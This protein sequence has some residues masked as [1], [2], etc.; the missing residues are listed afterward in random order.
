MVARGPWLLFTDADTKHAPNSVASGLQEARESSA[1]LLSYSPKQEVGSLAERAL[2]PVIFA[3]LA[4][5]Y[6]PKQVSDPNSPVAAANGQYLLIRREVY[7][8]IG[9]HAAV[10]TAILEDVEL[11]KRTKQA[12]YALR[13]RM[14]DLVTTRM[15]R[16]FGEMWEGWTKNLALLFPNVRG[17]AVKRAIE[18]LVIV[19]AAAFAIVSALQNEKLASLIAA[20]VTLQW[21]YLFWK[22][23]DLAHFDRLSTALSLLGLPLFA[24]LL[25]NSGISHKRGL[26][27]WKGREYAVPGS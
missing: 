27:R 20:A 13:F 18:F 5:T 26:V 10:A 4:L 23:I 1:D 3:E 25:W 16:S 21:L 22:R 2:M 11:A 24:V 7:D 9:G 19:A 17:L 12:G 8:A 6:P 14:S 15:Y